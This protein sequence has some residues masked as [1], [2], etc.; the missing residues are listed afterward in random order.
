VGNQPLPA[1]DDP[2]TDSLGVDARGVTLAGCGAAAAVGSAIA[3]QV[4]LSMLDHGHAFSRMLAWQVSSWCFWGLAAAFVLRLGSR[5]SIE[6]SIAGRR[7]RAVRVALVGVALCAAHMVVTAQLTVWFQP[8]LPLPPP[9]FADAFAG[10]IAST[11]VVDLFIFAVLL[12]AGSA[13]GARHRTRALERREARLEVELA[14]AQLEALRLE[15]H[16]HFLFNT[17]NSIAALIRVKDNPRALEMLLGLSELMRATVDGPRDHLVPLSTEIDFVRRYVD[18]QRER[19]ADRLDIRW[20]I[21]EA[22]LGVPVPTLLLQPLV[23]NAIRHGAAPQPGR[24]EITICAR[25]R[26]GRLQLSVSDA[27]AGLPAG[28]DITRDAGTGL[29]NSASRL[30][31]LYG[32]LASLEVRRGDRGGTVVELILPRTRVGEPLRTIA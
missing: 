26:S 28:F 21:D 29:R 6:T 22:A 25:L 27:G 3:T 4:Y 10:Q 18:L 5:L 11:L 20:D 1:Y 15:I 17:L 19:F 32:D 31:Q 9:T 14:R 7:G 16:P 24:C 30:K 13:I 12:T 8:F 23:E 2:A